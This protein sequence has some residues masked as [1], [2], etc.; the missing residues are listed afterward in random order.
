MRYEEYRAHDGVGLAA[1][2]ADGQIQPRE[3]LDAALRRYHQV[4]PAINAI[5][6]LME[7]EGWAIASKRPHGPF[8]G[9]PFLIKDLLQDYA[10]YP[11]AS[12]TGPLRAI[13]AERH[14]LLVR[15]WLDAGLVIFGKTTTPEFGVMPATQSRT[16]GAT[17]NPWNLDRTPGGSSGGSAAAVAAG[18]VPMA[19]GN[20]AGGSIRIPASHTGLVGLKPGRGTV[21]CGPSGGDLLHGIVGEGVVT[22]S[23]RDTALMLDIMSGPDPAARFPY[24]QPERAF[25]EAIRSAPRPLRIG[26]T[27]E[28]PLGTPVHPEAVRAVEHTAALLE[29]LGHRLEPAAPDLDGPQLAMDFIWVLAADATAT[30][31]AVRRLT[32]AATRD[33][34]F[35]VT[36]MARLGRTLSG[37]V[38]VEAFTRWDQYALALG[39]FHTTYDL[40]L[41]PTVAQPPV[42]VGRPEM[43]RPQRALMSV[44]AT[45]GAVEFITNSRA[46]RDTIVSDLATTPFTQLANITGRPAIT[47]PLY[48]GPGGMPIGSQFVGGL[49]SEFLLLQLAAQLEAAQPWGHLQPPE[50]PEFDSPTPPADLG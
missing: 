45:L 40:L 34:D 7:Q 27:V 8:G 42:R 44:M 25:R 3:L 35:L 9:V 13:K 20:D 1:L 38:L 28:S 23:V 22:R 43:S 30:L 36:L 39:Q 10:G 49:G 29:S 50:P 46:Y 11:T 41:T 17:R 15:R 5:S 37:R 47:V 32:G 12:G 21:P 18:I 26:F 4:D 48:Q 33:F 16:F 24:R 19:G 14:S 31:A 2:V 6:L